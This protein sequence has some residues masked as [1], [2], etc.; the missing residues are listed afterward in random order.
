LTLSTDKRSVQ[1][2]NYSSTL[3]LVREEGAVFELFLPLTLSTVER[4]GGEYSLELFFCLRPSTVE[5]EEGAVF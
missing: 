3:T 2:L 4:K 1:F 5:R